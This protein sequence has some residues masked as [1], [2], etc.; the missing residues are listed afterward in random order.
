[1][2]KL[3]LYDT[4]PDL[5]EEWDE[6]KNGSMKNY[7]QG[8]NKKFGGHVVKIIIISGVPVLEIEQ[9]NHL[10]VQYVQIN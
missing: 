4:N 2:S 6:E 5:R 8:M 3:T 1:M 9:E 10:D 7:T